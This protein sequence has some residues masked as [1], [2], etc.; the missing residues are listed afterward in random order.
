MDEYYFP[1]TPMTSWVCQLAQVLPG[2]KLQPQSQLGAQVNVNAK[3][4]IIIG[5]CVYH[6]HE[7]F[8]FHN[9][10]LQIRTPQIITKF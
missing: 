6:V 2:Q 8:C 4:E 5:K 9:S 1:A 7:K 3:G 10:Y